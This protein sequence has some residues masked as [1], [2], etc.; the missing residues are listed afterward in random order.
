MDLAFAAVAEML[1]VEFAE[2]KGST[3]VTVVTECAHSLP[4]ADPYFLEQAAR[5][6]LRL[7]AR[8][9]ARQTPEPR[10]N[11]FTLALQRRDLE[12]EGELL[13]RLIAVCRGSDA[14]LAQADVDR[15]LRADVSDAADA[16][17]R[18]EPRTAQ[19]GT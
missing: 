17:Q 19:F 18:S 3:V 7:L 14:P 6:R 4:R 5:A 1:A 15:I 2:L 10:P 16:P 11:P 13:D 12:L 8:V 9:Q